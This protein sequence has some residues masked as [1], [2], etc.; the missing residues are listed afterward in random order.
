MGLHVITGFRGK[1][2]DLQPFNLYTGLSGEEARQAMEACTTATRFHIF[3]N[4]GCWQKNNPN[5][6]PPAAPPPATPPPKGTV[7]T[8]TTRKR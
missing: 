7:D 5:Y 4:G 8:T 2:H 6:Q 3:Q 1:G